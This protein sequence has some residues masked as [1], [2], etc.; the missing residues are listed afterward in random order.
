MVSV[1]P[2]AWIPLNLLHIMGCYLFL[3]ACPKSDFLPEAGSIW[4]EL[5]SPP[6]ALMGEPP[7][8]MCTQPGGQ[9]TMQVPFSFTILSVLWEWSIYHC[10][11]SNSQPNIAQRVSLTA[12]GRIC[13]PIMLAYKNKHKC[14]ANSPQFNVRGSMDSLLTRK[15]SNLKLEMN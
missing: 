11:S 8:L 7:S 9:Q 2:S 12:V 6:C 15:I 10:I 3:K 4:S 5:T 14:Q 13:S 1:H